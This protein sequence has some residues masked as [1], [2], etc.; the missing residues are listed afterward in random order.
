M[1]TPRSEMTRGPAVLATI[2]ALALVNL[3]LASLIAAAVG[4]RG[5]VPLWAALVLL[6]VGAAAA[7][8]A[9]TLWRG[10]LNSVRTH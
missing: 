1:M 8:V 10:Y 6:V 7:A 3:G 2:A 9:V 5:F 4:A